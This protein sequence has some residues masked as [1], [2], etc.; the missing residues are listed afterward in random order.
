[1]TEKVQILVVEDEPAQAEVLAEALEREGY[2]V[3][4]A[5]YSPAS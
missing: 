3:T 4:T 2:A 1:M 5:A